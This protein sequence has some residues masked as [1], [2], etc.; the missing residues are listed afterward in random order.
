MIIIINYL[1]VHVGS[2]FLA[3][4][5]GCLRH[6]FKLCLSKRT[7]IRDLK[8]RIDKMSIKGFIIILP[9]LFVFSEGKITVRVFV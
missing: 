6:F 9:T 3:M 1:N 8:T 7:L 4:G 5:Y 2:K